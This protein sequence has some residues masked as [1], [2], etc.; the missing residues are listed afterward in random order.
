MHHVCSP[1]D[2]MVPVVFA[3]LRPSY[4]YSV[5]PTRLCLRASRASTLGALRLR[6][7]KGDPPAKTS[8]LKLVPAAAPLKTEHGLKLLFQVSASPSQRPAAAVT[9]AA[10]S[11]VKYLHVPHEAGATESL[12]HCLPYSSANFSVGW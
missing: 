7:R 6:R 1:T 5:L 3:C 2:V 12:E 9:A 4:F 10:R 11:V 8:S